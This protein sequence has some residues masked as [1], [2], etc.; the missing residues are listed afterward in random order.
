[1]AKNMYLEGLGFRAIDILLGIS[2][3]TAYR[4]VRQT[5]KQ[6]EI[7]PNSN[8]QIDLTSLRLCLWQTR[9]QNLSKAIQHPKPKQH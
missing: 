8:Q 1:M 2:H 7:K 4:W 3:Q 6:H 5:G 9:Y